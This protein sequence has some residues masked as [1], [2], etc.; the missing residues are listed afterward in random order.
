V[1]S[2][3]VYCGSSSGRSPKYAEAARAFATLLAHQGLTLVYGGGNV[4]LMGVVADAALAAGGRVIGVIP[5]QLVRREIA[6]RG[7]TE[8]HVVQTMHERKALMAEKSDAFATLPGG[9]GTLDELCEM[10]TWAQLGHHSKPCALLN[11]DGYF[12]GLLAQVDRAV[13]DGFTKPE[14]RPFVRV[15]QDTAGL[16]AALR[17]PL[18]AVTGPS[19]RP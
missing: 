3:C 4:G 19:I 8:L 15:A 14:Y 7:V 1:K 11:L 9:F 16:L 17:R 2:V 6:H 13:A 10:I 5:E 18:H 12:D